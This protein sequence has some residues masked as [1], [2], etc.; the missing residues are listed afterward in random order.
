[1][2]YCFIHPTTLQIPYLFKMT[3]VSDDDSIAQQEDY[4]RWCGKAPL[5]TYE[6]TAVQFASQYFMVF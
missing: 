4:I 6:A 3:N 2:Q 1:M 5:V